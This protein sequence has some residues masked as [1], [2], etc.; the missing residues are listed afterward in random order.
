MT[1]TIER[2]ACLVHARGALALDR[3][4]IMGVL[5]VT[6]DSFSDGGRYLD[7]QR[8]LARAL[9]M[10]REG[11]AIIDVG[12]ESTRPGAKP[13]PVEEEL[14]RVM[15]VIER[16]LEHELLVSIDTR[17]PEVA[18]R[19]LA[20]G[21][22]ILNDVEGLRSPRMREIAAAHGAGVVIMHMQGKPQTMQ[23]APRY[24]DVV[25]EVAA[26][27]ERQAKAAQAAGIAPE[28]I[29]ID[30]GIGFGKRIEH[31][32]ALLAATDRLA[33]GGRAV[34]IGLSRKSFL[35]KIVAPTPREDHIVRP[36]ER[37]LPAAL[38][39][40]AVAALRGARL[41]RTHDVEATADALAALHALEHAGRLRSD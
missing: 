13:V 10:V 12:G 7:P 9:A 30:P 5:N 18:A 1:R 36:P 6:P 11:A 25:A 2:P 17:R 20:A 38:A 33:A 35:G 23:R 40:T 31:N 39:L 34:L 4:R 26:W 15:P 27:L 22:A 24:D 3:P 28:A 21:V 16:L 32:L 19:A 37:R 29:A 41:F 8:A 14:R